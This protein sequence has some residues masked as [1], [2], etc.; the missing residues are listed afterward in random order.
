MSYFLFSIIALCIWVVLTNNRTCHSILSLFLLLWPLIWV[1]VACALLLLYSSSKKAQ[2]LRQSA[3][4][5]CLISSRQCWMRVLFWITQ[6]CVSV[7][8]TYEKVFL[9]ELGH[10]LVNTQH[11]LWV[12]IAVVNRHTHTKLLVI[13]ESAYRFLVVRGKKRKK[14]KSLRLE[15][16]KAMLKGEKRNGEFEW[17]CIRSETFVQTM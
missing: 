8:S 6:V 16:H 17:L 12:G 11:H 4:A 7:C 15:N 14:K 1:Q 9:G 13:E 10:H 5:C 2:T 3:H